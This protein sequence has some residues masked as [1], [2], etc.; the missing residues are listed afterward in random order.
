MIAPNAFYVPQA[1]AYPAYTGQPS[2][3]VRLLHTN[4]LHEHWEGMAKAV[5]G[6]KQQSWEGYATD[7][8]VL[9]L[10]SG[11]TNTGRE[12]KE[13]T[14]STVMGNLMGW[15]ATTSGN[16]EFDLPSKVYYGTLNA[17]AQFPT[18]LSNMLIPNTLETYQA[19]QMRKLVN[20]PYIVRGQQGTY[21]L[22]GITRPAETA[23][24]DKAHRNEGFAAMNLNST[25][26]QLKAQVQQL[27][28]QGIRN[29]VV[30]SHMGL[31]L[32]K[33]LAQ[34]VDG[35][36]VI[37]SGDSHDKIKELAPGKSI[38]TS[39]NGSPVLIVQ[40]GANARYMGQLD[41]TFDAWGRVTPESLQVL[42]TD[43]F[44]ADPQAMQAIEQYTTPKVTLGT[45]AEFTGTK[46][47]HQKPNALAQKMADA[48]RQHANSEIAFV[49]SRE[50]REPLLH[51]PISNWAL[52]TIMPYD[53]KVVSLELT[54]QEITSALAR[55]AEA[56]EWSK[57]KPSPLL[58][59]SGLSC[60]MDRQ[61]GQVRDVMVQ[62]RQTG[63]YEPIN[64]KQT[65]RVAMTDYAVK[66]PK[67][68]P[69]F[70]QPDRVI[71]QSP[72]TLQ[73]LFQ[74]QLQ[75]ATLQGKP[76]SVGTVDNRLT[77]VN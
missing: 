65:Y 13:W 44:F 62:N 11:D 69:E 23:K 57:L 34:S 76:Y 17:V 39:P 36:G 28:S 20:D 12:A 50:I 52:K 6:L 31:A 2:A 63:R 21:A 19:R 5:T 58:H 61:T 53:S 45:V 60:V 70:A 55:S 33:E 43:G 7:R 77:I 71:W 30:L 16:H 48:V 56:L 4:D 37:I 72:V 54:G 75:R 42:S 74:Q 38:F 49:R 24:L 25:K 68:F 15:H 64:P 1:Q 40:A 35:I 18:L 29:I 66:E 32:D 67:E 51:G 27:H 14:L 46:D 3:R 10:N 59:A 22:L 26:E 41:L 9:R 47:I 73:R 8:D